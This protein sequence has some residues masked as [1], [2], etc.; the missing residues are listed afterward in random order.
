MLTAFQCKFGWNKVKY[1]RITITHVCFVA[2][3]IAWSPGSCLSTR[4][5]SLV[6]KQVPQNPVMDKKW[7]KSAN[8][9]VFTKMSI[10]SRIVKGNK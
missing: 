6:F 8:M 10:L 9:K 2:L 5:V 7:G 3:T 1:A 4:P